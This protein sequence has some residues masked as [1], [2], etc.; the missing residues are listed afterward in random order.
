MKPRLSSWIFSRNPRVLLVVLASLW[1][2]QIVFWGVWEW[3]REPI[4]VFNVP[5]ASNVT[6][7]VLS[8]EVPLSPVPAQEIPKSPFLSSNSD[9]LSRYFD[10]A[11]ARSEALSGYVDSASF[12]RTTNAESGA[13]LGASPDGS[14]ESSEEADAVDLSKI[15]CYRGF[16][17]TSQGVRIAF[18]EDLASASMHRLRIGACFKEWTLQSIHR[19][20]VVFSSGQDLSLTLLRQKPAAVMPN[21]TNDT[22]TALEAVS[23]E[24]IAKSEENSLAIQEEQHP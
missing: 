4:R 15:L 2:A 10:Y 22:T 23:V 9:V 6:Q 14:A 13:S 17:Q 18:I 20:E 1:L 11:K 3:R 5:Q 8:V 7:A 19:D 24:T 16:L 21:Q 12:D